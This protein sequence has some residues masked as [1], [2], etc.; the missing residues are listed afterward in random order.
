MAGNVEGY[1]I[2]I[3]VTTLEEVTKVMETMRTYGFVDIAVS[4][5]KIETFMEEM[6]RKEAKRYNNF[7]LA[8][9]YYA[10]A[11]NEKNAK[12]IEEV[13]DIGTKNLPTRIRITADNEGIARRTMNM[14]ATVTLDKQG[15]VKYTDTEPKRFWLTSKGMEPAKKLVEDVQG[16][17]R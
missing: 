2:E 15:L 7:I 1:N 12:T 14:I 5:R 3:K 10:K 16:G 4:P 9:L 6:R 8:T 11:S 13:L 17:E